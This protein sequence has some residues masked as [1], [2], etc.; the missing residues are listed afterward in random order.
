MNGQRQCK[1][2]LEPSTLRTRLYAPSFPGWGDRLEERPTLPDRDM[3][4]VYTT[5]SA[6][7]ALGHRE[8]VSQ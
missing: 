7:M 3:L 2:N 5:G 6:S 8:Y 4:R 1:R